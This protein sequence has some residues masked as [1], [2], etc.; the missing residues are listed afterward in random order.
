MKKISIK[1]KAEP[2]LR[3][4]FLHIS[5]NLPLWNGIGNGGRN[6]SGTDSC[7]KGE[8]HFIR[9]ANVYAPYCSSVY[10]SE[11]EY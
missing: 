1:Q 2:K 9:Y 6:S 4:R 7:R 11:I 5:R 3:F 8:C 10:S